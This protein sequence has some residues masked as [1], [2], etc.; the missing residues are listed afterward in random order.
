MRL[1]SVTKTNQQQSFKNKA[2]PVCIVHSRTDNLPFENGGFY[3][4]LTNKS[5]PQLSCF[6]CMSTKGSNPSDEWCKAGFSCT[7]VRVSVWPP[8]GPPAVQQQSPHQNNCSCQ[9]SSPCVTT[10][11]SPDI[12]Q[13]HT[14]RQ[15][16]Q[17]THL[18]RCSRKSEW[19]GRPQLVRCPGQADSQ[20][21]LPWCI[22]H[23][24]C[25]I[26]SPLE[27][28]EESLN[29]DCVFSG[30]HQRSMWL[31]QLRLHRNAETCVWDFTRVPVDR[32]R[33]KPNVP[34]D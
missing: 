24:C 20:A 8:W 7:R 17:N 11:E 16:H 10:Q 27:I 33:P 30:S 19:V 21:T 13:T 1:K 14:Q 12:W 32:G 15:C 2:H 25:N 23:L 9:H 28:T 22:V 3:Q 34:S 18:I 31:K 29:L 5:T 6:V 26:C 4:L